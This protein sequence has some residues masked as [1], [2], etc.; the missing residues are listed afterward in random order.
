MTFL[1]WVDEIT[2]L[3]GGQQKVNTIRELRIRGAQRGR[4]RRRRTSRFASELIY[5]R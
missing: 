2:L 4:R 5:H 3:D 1:S